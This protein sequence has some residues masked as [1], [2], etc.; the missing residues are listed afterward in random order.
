V[1]HVSTRRMPELGKTWQ[2]STSAPALQGASESQLKA[3]G[4]GLSSQR[5]HLSN[6][7][8]KVAGMTSLDR[9]NKTLLDELEAGE[10]L[11]A[12]RMSMEPTAPSVSARVKLHSLQR[13]RG[14]GV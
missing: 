9:D 6:C 13:G 1:Q 3:D 2:T 14:L 8:G 11:A 4:V 12:L 5:A 10:P 7:A